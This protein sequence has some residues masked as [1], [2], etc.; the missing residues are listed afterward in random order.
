MGVAEAGNG[1]WGGYFRILA[2]IGAINAAI[3]AWYYLRVAIAMY[4]R[5]TMRPLENRRT[6]PGLAG[7]TVC[8]ALTVGFGAYPWLLLSLV[9][10]AVP[11]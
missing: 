7:L 5:S 11:Q 1:T 10:D 6:V 3:A 4:L 2:L 9:N 8:A